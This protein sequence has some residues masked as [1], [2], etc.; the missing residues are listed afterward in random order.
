MFKPST[1]YRIQFHKDFNFNSFEEIIPYLANLGIDTLYASPIFEAI[2]GSTHG[3]DVVNPLKI[4][5]EIGTEKQLLKISKKLKEA[6]I[7]W[8]Q[9]IVPN[10]MAF[11][12]DNKW[13]MDV[14]ENGPKSDFASFFDVNFNQADGKLMV[15]FLGE[16]LED[17]IKHHALQLDEGDGKFVLKSGD[18]CWPLNGETTKKLKKGDLKTYNQDP[19]FLIELAQAQ[20]YRLCNWQETNS[21]INY[22]RF[23]TVN[24]LIC[25]N[26]QN[27]ESFDLY[28][29]YIFELV[30]KGIFQGLRI[31][32]V[33]GLYD[34][35]QYLDRLR[36]AVGEDVYIVVEK[37]LE[38][39]EEMPS[40]WQAQGTTGYEF[41]AMENN[42]LTNT[43]AK[44][45]FDNLYQQVIGKKLNP[46]ALIY[47][48]KKAILF[49]HMHGELDNLFS[50]LMSLEIIEVSKAELVHLKLALAEMLIQMPVYRYYNHSFPLSAED[51]KRVEQLF[52]PI[53]KD[54]NL[55]KAAGQLQELL[56]K[57]PLDGDQKLNAK[58]GQFYQRCMQFTGPLMAKG[59]EDTVMFTYNRFIGHNEVGDA[60]DA[61]GISTSEFH[62]KMSKRQEHWPLSLNGSSTHDTKKGED[63]RARLNVLSDLPTEWTALVDDLM[64]FVGALQVAQPSFKWLHPN[65]LY[66]I[67]QTLIGALPFEGTD[68]DDFENRFE[69]FIQKALREAKKRSD[70][71]EPNEKYEEELNKFSQTILSDKQDSWI[72]IKVFLQ[73]ISDYSVVNSL[74]QVALKFTCPGIPDVYQ[75]TE[76]WDLS[77]V[78]PDNRRPV[79][80][81]L[82]AKYLD[83]IENGSNQKLW[84]DRFSGKIKLW[85]TKKLIEVRKS[86]RDVFEKGAY[87]PLKVKGKY[88]KHVIAYGRKHQQSW[89]IS[90]IPLGMAQ[91]CKSANT[92]PQTIDWADTEI[93]LPVE[94]AFNWEDLLAEKHAHKELVNQAI[95]VGEI[96]AS[97]PVA[98]LKL[99]PK[100]NKRSAGI[101]MHISC[102]PSTFGIGDFGR[103]AFEF[104]DFLHQCRQKYWQIL[105]LNPTKSENGH[106]PYSSNSAMAGNDLLISPES[107]VEDGLLTDADL[108][109]F[110]IPE[111]SSVDFEQVEKAK[112]N[113]LTKA[114]QNFLQLTNDE[115]VKEYTSFCITAS[116]WLD[117]FSVYSSIKQRFNNLEWYNW[118]E[119]FKR[120]HPKT[121]ADFE[122]EHHKEIE[123]MK[124]RQF[125]FYRQWNKLKDYA[126]RRHI[127]IVGDLPFYLDYDSVEVWSQPGNFLLDD[128]LNK[129]MVAGVPPDYFNEK[130]QLWG[131]P[132][133]NWETMKK[134]GFSW[135]V[136]RLKK[137]ITLFDIIRLD[138]FRAFSSYWAVPAEAEDATYGKW[139]EGPG[140]SFFDIIKE[141]L[142]QLPFIAEDLGEITDDVEELRAKFEL[143]GM[144]VLQFSFG[145][146]IA[147]STHIP[148][149]YQSTKCIAYSG[150]HD[151]NTVLGWFK[152]EIDSE[153]RKRVSDYLGIAATEDNLAK[154]ILKTCYA[155]IAE[156]AIVPIQD[157]LN[158]DETAR[159]NVPGTN[160]GNWLWK[161][162][163]NEI[164]SVL[165]A[166]L[167]AQ[168]EMYGRTV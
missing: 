134:D 1:T 33:D 74:A 75:G 105:P 83:E 35:K 51:A 7:S 40:D 17:A 46:Q 44:K 56:L 6:G 2:P 135:W 12:F 82:R 62:D 67:I 13:L 158:L 139:I 143:P 167:R 118:P 65:D 126:N 60:P 15:P 31:D 109:T 164:S 157:L 24:S 26:I 38:D 121:L 127:Q 166:W 155:S 53:L 77:L 120:R 58:I 116:D 147:S 114:Y 76:L 36:K 115:L 63:V 19:D 11:H 162:K 141:N 148:H 144:K 160:E 32:H 69:Q 50:L 72:K 52:H 149:N 150:T 57:K 91:L 108:S 163:R 45:P 165:S 128:H 20:H 159:M 132:I 140:T 99:T 79:N 102:L 27:Q 104:V 89:I 92:T 29:Q 112:D 124:W 30:E 153:T 34:P 70:W 145:A 106:S 80:Y 41:L 131:M 61:F 125:I 138:H 39:G 47:E 110:H 84:G 23:F 9:D 85:L 54:K 18:A 22:R 16:D 43:A 103:N 101:L 151:N 95:P 133:F 73:E 14:L 88:A 59:V 107:L 3:Y 10:H 64:Q 113:L 86:N 28:H 81:A 168:T 37:I 98:I 137:N 130:G 129:V 142:G 123:E 87:I 66:L 21:N 48:K 55:A 68:G 71:A 94:A 111:K 156:V 119:A 146:D 8:L 93:I 78:D 152:T 49:E 100:N 90:A 154:M 136:N 122:K 117:D 96:F 42:L 97:F 5:P 4:N 25:L 161:L